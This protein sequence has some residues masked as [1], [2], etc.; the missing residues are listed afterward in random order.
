[1]SAKEEEQRWRY[2]CLFAFPSKLESNTPTEFFI[3]L[4]TGELN[5]K[6]NSSW[7]LI[8]NSTAT[9]TVERSRDVF[10]IS[11][12]WSG[13]RGRL[14]LEERGESQVCYHP[15]PYDCFQLFVVVL[16]HSLL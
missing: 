5:L 14:W 9:S 10:G 12:S 1:M 7:L 8:T 15:S 11:G 6:H 16:D 13:G 4:K 3:S 2:S